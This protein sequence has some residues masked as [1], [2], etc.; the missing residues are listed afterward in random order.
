MSS[1]TYISVIYEGSV[2]D[3]L[4]FLIEGTRCPF[5]L[6]SYILKA[7]HPTGEHK[8]VKFQTQTPGWIALKRK[9]NCVWLRLGEF[10][11]EMFPALF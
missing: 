7:T 11:A 1:G 5:Q 6:V 2:A 10:N 9:H 4:I 3:H 8:W